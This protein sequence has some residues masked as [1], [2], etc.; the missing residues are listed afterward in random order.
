M[1]ML[2]KQLRYR[3][4]YRQRLPSFGN[5]GVRTMRRTFQ[6]W[7]ALEEEALEEEALEEES[8]GASSED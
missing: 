5:R 4:I 1:G 7:E 6:N 3:A 8:A 2:Y